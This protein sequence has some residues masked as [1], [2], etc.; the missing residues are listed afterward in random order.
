MV[1]GNNSGRPG[2]MSVYVGTLD[3][4]SFVMPQFNVYIS[5]ALPFVKIDESLNNFEE[6]RQ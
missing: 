4:A 5:R 3:D 2:I 1:L 6:G